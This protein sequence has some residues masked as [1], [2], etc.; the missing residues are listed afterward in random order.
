MTEPQKPYQLT[1]EIRPQYLYARVS[2]DAINQKIVVDYLHEITGKCRKLGR[3]HLMIERDIPATLSETDTFFTG[4]EFAH[5]GI[6]KIRIAFVDRREE[7][8]EHLEFAMLIVNNRGA[9]LKLFH[10]PASAEKW[11]LHS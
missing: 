2:C 10:D 1:F 11:L 5:M 4:T 3:K 6:D 7:N 9:D 8:T